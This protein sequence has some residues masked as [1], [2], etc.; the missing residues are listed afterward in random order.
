M[1][2]HKLGITYYHYQNKI[3]IFLQHHN[4]FRNVYDICTYTSNVINLEAS[5]PVQIRRTI[6]NFPS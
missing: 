3:N 4:I 2:I 6:L 1:Q 5:Y